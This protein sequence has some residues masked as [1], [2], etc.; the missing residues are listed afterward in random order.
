LAKTGARHIQTHRNNRRLLKLSGEMQFEFEFF[1]FCSRLILPK[2]TEHKCFLLLWQIK[3][4]NSLGSENM[5]C[6]PV[7]S[8]LTENFGFRGVAQPA[9]IFVSPAVHRITI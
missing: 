2:A 3:I 5:L 9:T 8:L 7:H 4:K 1:I 6:I